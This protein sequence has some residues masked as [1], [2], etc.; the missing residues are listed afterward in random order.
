MEFAISLSLFLP[1]V[2]FSVA[3]DPDQKPILRQIKNT[4]AIDDF[5]IPDNTVL[6]GKQSNLRF[7]ESYTGYDW[8]KF[9]KNIKETNKMRLDYTVQYLNSKFTGDEWIKIFDDSV[10][11]C[12]TSEDTQ[13][14]S[15][16]NLVRI[17]LGVPDGCPV[18]KG[19][20]NTEDVHFPL[21]DEEIIW[22]IDPRGKTI[23]ILTNMWTDDKKPPQKVFTADFYPIEKGNGFI[24]MDE[25]ESDE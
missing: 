15:I 6:S 1:L 14:A 24:P 5:R 12:D 8:V 3:Y 9:F 17:L 2:G 22:N 25:S 19:K 23:R 7:D 10:L 11:F 21:E 13:D 4:I 16:I 20:K 18:Q